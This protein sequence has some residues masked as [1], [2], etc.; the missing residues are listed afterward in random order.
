MPAIHRGL[1]E[2]FDRAFDRN[3][4]D[5]I[6]ESGRGLFLDAIQAASC[7]IA[8]QRPHVAGAA[9]LVEEARRVLQ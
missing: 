8:L 5:E 1:G 4:V 2:L 6:G 7:A 3:R 9:S